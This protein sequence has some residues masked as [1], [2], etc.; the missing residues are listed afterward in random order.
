M[1][2]E[3]LKKGY[4]LLLTTGADAALPVVRFSYPIQR[5][6]KI[7]EGRVSMMWPENLT[8]RSQDLMPTYHDVGQFYWV[9]VSS[10]LTQKK[11]F[12]EHT[13]PIEIPESQVQDI[14]N[15][16]DWKIAEMKYH[17]LHPRENAWF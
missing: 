10:F 12:A 15:E 8:A 11:L 2:P 5:A 14:D 7:A 16:E 1:T 17:I 3:Q 4:D 13:V 6:L 9:K